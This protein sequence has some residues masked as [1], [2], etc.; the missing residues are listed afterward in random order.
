MRSLIPGVEGCTGR[1]WVSMPGVVAIELE[2][3]AVAN[4]PRLPYCL[5]S[6]AA[7][8]FVAFATEPGDAVRDGLK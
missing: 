2:C 5:F 4:D 3:F 8:K 6:D 1:D 7:E